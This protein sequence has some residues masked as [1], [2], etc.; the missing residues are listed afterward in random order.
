MHKRRLSTQARSMWIYGKHAVK[1]AILNKKRNILRLILLESN[2]NFL[3]EME[4]DHI[5]AEIV[6][7]N[8]FSSIF[9]KNSTHQGYAALIE[10]T[11]N[12]SIEDII[13]DMTGNQP[14][15]ILDQI[16]DP[17]NIGSILRASAVLDAKA[18]VTPATH[19]PKLTPA[20]SKVA[21]GALEIVPLV[22]VTNIAHTINLLKQNGFW[23]IG[24]EETSSKTLSE[25]DLNGKF[26]F[27][28][29]NEGNGMRKLTREKCDFLVHLQ[30]VNKFATLNAA[31]AATIALYESLRQRTKNVNT[32]FTR[33]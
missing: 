24:L 28:I 13:T 21:S 18:I 26:A 29:G 5:K 16:T 22:R 19:C 8:V 17:Q 6:E 11:D 15:I 1:A 12:Y 30:G 32:L 23:I 9:G 10:Y 25:I 4:C 33:F 20:I 7:R 3:N 31:Q 14:I 2:K 27:I